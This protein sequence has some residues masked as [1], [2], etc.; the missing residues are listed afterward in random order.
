MARYSIERHSI[1]LSFKKSLSSN[2][3]KQ[4]SD[5]AT[6]TGLHAVKVASKK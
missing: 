6:K 5:T 2:Y 4:L 1:D 3:R